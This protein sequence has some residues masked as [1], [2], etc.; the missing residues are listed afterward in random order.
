MPDEKITTMLRRAAS[1][2][3]DHDA[4]LEAIYDRLHG[5]AEAQLRGERPGHT[6][7]PTLIVHDAYLKLIDQSRAQWQDRA[8][9]MA[10]AARAMRRIIIDYAR[11]RNREKRG[12]G[13]RPV[14]LHDACSLTGEAHVD[15]G[16]LLEALEAMRRIA[17]RAA[18]VTELRFFSGL[19]N[20]E[21]AMSLDVSER[22]VERDWRWAQAWL[23]RELSRARDEDDE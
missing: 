2:E 3:V 20:A 17:D 10:V 16:A 13:C 18:T 21:V 23:Q 8:H 15:G 14:T 5:L 19:T 9:F 22:T 1:G 6:L 11:R 12:G 4:L 7:Q